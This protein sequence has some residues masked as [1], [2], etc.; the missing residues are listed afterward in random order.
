MITVKFLGGSKKSF[1]VD[2][3]TIEKNDLT[4]E[5]LLDHL[6]K[7]KP[8][9]GNK[10]DVQNLLVAVN[11]IDS[12]AIDGQLT[13]LKNNDVVS[14]IPII[15]GGSFSRIHFKISNSYVE[16]FDI[17]VKQKLGVDFLDFL[18]K[19]F[20]NLIIQGISSKY[21]LN[22]SHA[23]K[24]ISISHLAKENHTLISKKIDTDILLRFAGTTQIQDA[25]E[26]VGIKNDDGFVI[27][28]IGKQLVIEKL[29]K[30]LK[31]DLSDN[32]LSKNNQIFLRKKFNITKKHMD[33]I[34]SK[35]PLEDLLVEK[36]TILIG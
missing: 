30:F 15:H 20:P 4:I 10:L 9:N 35:N 31:P 1:S 34:L 29:Y 19:K 16:L 18:R 23:Q 7:N 24:I 21:I 22:K 25:I 14:I 13:K 36:A 33:S 27:I 32:P 26:R 3:L 6:V 2:S 28:A 8:D 17:T 5:Q 12:S 11:G